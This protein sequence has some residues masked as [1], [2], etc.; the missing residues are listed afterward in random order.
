MTFGT[1]K[2]GASGSGACFN[3]SA[4]P[5][6]G[7]STSSAQR[8]IRGLIVRQHLRHRLD[9][10]RIEFVQFPDVVENFVELLS[11]RR[12]F[13]FGEIEVRKFRHAQNIFPAD[14]QEA[15]SALSFDSAW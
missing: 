12:Q 8:R 14:F 11:V 15:T 3:N 6:Q 5:W 7:T 4:A 1:L 10:R 2:Y 13:V 9:V